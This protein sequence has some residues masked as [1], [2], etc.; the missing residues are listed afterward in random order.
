MTVHTAK[1]PRLSALT[2]GAALL[3]L[4]SAC[5]GDGAG[6]DTQPGATPGGGIVTPPPATDVLVPPTS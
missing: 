3:L 4:G 6:G 1:R 5:N 2:V